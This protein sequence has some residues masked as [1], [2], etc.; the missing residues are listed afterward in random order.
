MPKRSFLA[1]MGTAQQNG[2]RIGVLILCTGNSARS[3]MA[4]GFLASFD[5]R[6]AV[7]SAGTKPAPRV[8]PFAIR[9]MKEAGIDISKG[10]PKS[11]QQ[12]VHQPFDYVITVCGDADKNC[13]N[14]TGKLGK[15]THIGFMDP[16]QATGTDEEVMAVFRRVREEI[17]TKFSAY[18]ETQIRKSL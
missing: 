16:A 9:A 12:F 6:L 1:A 4:A 3:Q 15:R 13:P 11:V 5:P 8:N 2:G 7:Y 17:R 18:Y 14:F 10:T